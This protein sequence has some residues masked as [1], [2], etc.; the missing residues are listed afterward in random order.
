MGEIC[1]KHYDVQG[2]ILNV[3]FNKRTVSINIKSLGDFSTVIGVAGG[4]KKARAI[5]GA[6]NGNLINVLVTD[7]DTARR[8]L[9]LG[10][11]L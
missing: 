9:D 6:I 8:V 1:G 2:N 7:S 11:S 3:D 4:E 5:L 10:E